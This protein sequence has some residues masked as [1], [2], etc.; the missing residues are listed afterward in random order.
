MSKC[1]RALKVKVIYFIYLFFY[2]K[3]NGQPS[4]RCCQ[5]S[6]QRT[7]SSA[8]KD[9][10]IL[11]CLNVSELLIIIV[12]SFFLLFLYFIKYNFLLLF[13]LFYFL[14]TKLHK[15]QQKYVFSNFSTELISV[16]ALI[17]YSRVC[18]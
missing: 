2:L 5:Q 16:P 17:R 13:S 4:K 9:H 8:G 3:K 15:C 12:Y 11:P 10:V 7:N 14:N 18:E 6:R 1:L